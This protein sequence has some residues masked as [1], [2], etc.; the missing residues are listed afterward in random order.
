MSTKKLFAFAIALLLGVCAYSQ[1]VTFGVKGGASANWIPGTFIDVGDNPV[2]NVGYY[3]G[4]A[5]SYDFSGGLFAQAEILYMRKGISTNNPMMGKYSRNISY[6]EIP[7]L[8]GISLGDDSLRLLLGPEFGVCTGSKVKA[9]VPNPSSLGKPR[10]FNLSIVLQATY[11]I[12][13]NL[14]VDLKY[15]FGVTPV[16]DEADVFGTRD[17]GH[18][19]G[20]MLGLSYFFGD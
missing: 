17:R 1:D 12:T 5:L 4:V 10:P 8:A 16:F 7:V 15:D 13:D 2:T 3:G 19:R 9:D 20:A 11:F 18:N 6:I 14:G